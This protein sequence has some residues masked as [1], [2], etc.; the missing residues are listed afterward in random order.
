MNP[1]GNWPAGPG[2]IPRETSLVILVVP[3]V[4]GG[5]GAGL[6]NPAEPPVAP[7][8]LEVGLSRSPNGDGAGFAG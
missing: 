3:A 1:A 7:R 5:G 8:T 2:G 6:P 4:D